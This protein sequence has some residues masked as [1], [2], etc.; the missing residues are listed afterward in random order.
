MAAIL[1]DDFYKH[2]FKYIRGLMA[3]LINGDD[4][5]LGAK[6]NNGV[7]NIKDLTPEEVKLA[8]EFNDDLEADNYDDITPERFNKIFASRKLKHSS[9]FKGDFSGYSNGLASGNRGNA[10]ES[11]F[12]RNYEDR[13]E[14]NIKEMYPYNELIKISHDGGKNNRRPL[15]FA[16]GKIGFGKVD[17]YEIG[18]KVTDV[19]LE[20]DEGDIYLSLK[21]GS[22]VTF[23]NA[24]VKTLFPESFF[25]NDTP[26][27]A[28]AKEL[29]DML[30]IDE[31]RFKDVFNNYIPN[32]DRRRSVKDTVDITDRLAENKTFDSFIKSAMGYGYILVHQI[33]GSNIEYVNLLNKEDMEKYIGDIKEAY[34]EYPIDGFAKRVDVIVKYDKISFKINIRNKQGGIYPSH[35]MTDYVF[36][37]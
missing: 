1:T 15:K 26:L 22:T 11:Y 25:E 19:T 18:D 12:I 4:V 36:N 2:D 21:S 32:S 23:V 14:A 6:G 5:R 35:I 13:F 9:F 7:V 10:F 27:S 33:Q 31:D 28:N 17:D 34:I 24:G 3:R 29:L 30:C 8:H 20:T 16:K 37:K